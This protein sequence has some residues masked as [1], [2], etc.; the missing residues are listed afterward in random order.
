MLYNFVD[1]AMQD[2]DNN[3]VVSMDDLCAFY[4]ESI[5]GGLSD[6]TSLEL[7][8]FICIQGFFVLLNCKQDR[9]KVLHDTKASSGT[10]AAGQPKSIL[11]NGKSKIT[12]IS[13]THGAVA[14][15]ID[16]G[17]KDTTMIDT[18]QKSTATTG[19]T[20]Q[21]QDSAT[22]ET[23]NSAITGGVGTETKPAKAKTPLA[24]KDGKLNVMMCVPPSEAEGLEGLWKIATQAENAKVSDAVFSLLI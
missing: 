5:S 8:G 18:T 3:K 9:L 2:E 14:Q 22:G 13:S 19:T 12:S 1:V 10:N 15:G 7:E 24:D 4:R 23:G 6:F 17:K 20:T 11:K 16:F 21:T